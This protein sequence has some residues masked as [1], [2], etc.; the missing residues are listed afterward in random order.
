MGLYDREYYRQ[1]GRNWNFGRERSMVTNLILINVGLYL[2]DVLSRGQLSHV[3]EVHAG[4]FRQPWYAWQLLTSGFVHDT[5]NIMHVGFNMFALWLF[6]REVE[7]HYGRWE[8]LRVYLSLVVLSSLGWVLVQVAMHTPPDRAML[9]AS[10]AVTGVMILYVMNFPRRVFYIWGILPLPAFV[11]GIFFVLEDLA[12]FSRGSQ[13]VDGPHV[14]Y[15]TH[16][17]GALCAFLYFQSGMNLGR[18]FSLGGRLPGL[19]KAPRLKVHEPA[20]ER[21]ESLDQ[22]VDRIL[23]KL[24]RE[25]ISSLTGEEQQILED[26]SRRYRRR[27]S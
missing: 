11:V 25:G 8:F 4:L 7:A 3:F 21:D 14:A 2:I 24:N 1:E 9:G 26:A 15:E 23:D 6:G 22:R 27:R 18:L 12:G 5:Q 20:P 10:G 13:D 16:L 19:P 17:A